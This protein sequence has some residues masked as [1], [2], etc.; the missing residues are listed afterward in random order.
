M[1]SLVNDMV[2]RRKFQQLEIPCYIHNLR[3]PICLSSVCF[4]V[5]LAFLSAWILLVIG[6][7]HVPSVFSYIS[8]LLCFRS[9]FSA[10]D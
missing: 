5:G 6:R 10:V 8:L 2:S 7:Q 1:V 9:W 4:S 3:W